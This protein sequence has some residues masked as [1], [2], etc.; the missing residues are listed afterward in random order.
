MLILEAS[1]PI[2]SHAG[3]G[4]AAFLVAAEADRRLCGLTRG[5]RCYDPLRGARLHGAPEGCHRWIIADIDFCPYFNTPHY[6]Y[7]LTDEGLAA[8]DAA[9]AAGDMWPAA[10]EDAASGL[11]GM[12][13]P[14]LL[15]GACRL[16]GPSQDLGKMRDSLGNI[17]DAWRDQDDGRPVSPVGGADQ[18]LVDLA[19]IARWPN[20]DGSPGSA[21]DH[22]DCLK[23]AIESAHAIAGEAKPSSRAED[24]VLRTLIGALRDL[25][26]R[27]ARVAAT[28]PLTTPDTTSV[29]G[30]LSWSMELE[31]IQPLYTDVTPVLICDLCYC[32][33]EYSEIRGL[34]ADPCNVKPSEQL[35]K[36]EKAS[37]M[38]A[39][40][41]SDPI[42]RLQIDRGVTNDGGAIR[43]LI[44]HVD[45]SQFA[46]AAG[47]YGPS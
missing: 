28:A 23:A 35:T 17:V 5:D 21:L 43:R 27:H 41:K 25:C 10:V 1:G 31:P 22:L 20:S 30:D 37:M 36:A 33:G 8:L 39:L 14:D 7:D 47:H 16:T 42:Y 3:L 44:G 34:A 32:L 18:A 4:A 29:G 19:T 40:Q 45:T 46:S 6:Y 15:E 24:A 26:R 12:T 9:K 11:G 2:C 13:L 38:K